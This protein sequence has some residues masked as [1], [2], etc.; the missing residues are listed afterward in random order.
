MKALLKH[1]GRIYLW[2]FVICVLFISG[3]TYQSL[4]RKSF[5]TQ[6]Y[7]AHELYKSHTLKFPAKAASFEEV[8]TYPTIGNADGKLKQN[9]K[10][11]LSIPLLNGSTF[12]A[13]ICANYFSFQPFFT[14]II[15]L[16]NCVLII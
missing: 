15:Y 12:L 16:L 4:S 10:S 3:A 11:F 9:A 13:D 5:S 8:H 2:Y 1:T 14:K 7:S 6:S